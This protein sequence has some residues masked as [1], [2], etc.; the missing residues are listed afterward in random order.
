MS[1]VI[2]LCT[3]CSAAYFPLRLICCR[4][5]RTDFTDDKVEVGVVETT[6]SLS[7]GSQI[8]TVT[9]PE[10]LSFIARIIGGTA[11]NGDRIQL[12]ND[13]SPDSGPVAYVPF[14]GSDV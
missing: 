5:G 8:A 14:R 3:N 4:C 7:D 13:S 6:T 1:A 2:Q 10:D 11:K 12:T 9:C